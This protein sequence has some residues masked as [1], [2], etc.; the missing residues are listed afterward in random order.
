M[1]VP[2]ILNLNLLF[3]VLTDTLTPYSVGTLAGIVKTTDW[4]MFLPNFQTFKDLFDNHKSGEAFQNCRR[5]PDIWSG[6]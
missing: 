6:T 4:S 3:D 2:C 5:D 1:P